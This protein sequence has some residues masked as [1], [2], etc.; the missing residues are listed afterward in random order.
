MGSDPFLATA[1]HGALFLDQAA[2]A[3]VRDLEAFLG[4][5]EAAG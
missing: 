2:T 5:G 4:E 1:D 3:L